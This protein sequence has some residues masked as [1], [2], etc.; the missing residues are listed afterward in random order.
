MKAYNQAVL[1]VF[2]SL[3]EPLG[4]VPLE[5]MACGTPVVGVAEGGIRE[6][7]INYKTGLL[8]ERD[9]YAFGAAIELILSDAQ[10]RLDMGQNAR[11]HVLEKWTWEQAIDT[12]EKNIS[13]VVV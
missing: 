8:T 1:T 5:S 11:Q 6:T 13:R 4:L 10:L 3:L 7:I 12:L 2:P 9:P